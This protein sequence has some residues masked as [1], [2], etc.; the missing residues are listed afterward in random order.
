MLI[1]LRPF[2]IV[3]YWLDK[4]TKYFSFGL[5]ISVFFCIML[6]VFC[7]YILNNALSWTQELSRILLVWLTFFGAAVVTRRYLHIGLTM[8]VERTPPKVQNITTVLGY[9]ASCFFIVALIIH[10]WRLSLFGT[11]Q[12]LTFLNISYFWCYVGI[13]VG[14]TF[15]FIQVLYLIVREIAAFFGKVDELKEFEPDFTDIET[16]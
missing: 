5:L 13:P 14:G 7:N 6:Q 4:L 8:L 10:G 12:T 3:A 16:Y 2:N 1:I 9:V 15:I 11:S